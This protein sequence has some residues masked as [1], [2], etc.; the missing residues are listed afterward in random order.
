M[1]PAQFVRLRIPGITIACAAFVGWLAYLVAAWVDSRDSFYFRLMLSDWD[2]IAAFAELF[3]NLGPLSML[4][5][6]AGLGLYAAVWLWSRP[7]TPLRRTLTGLCLLIVFAVGGIIWLASDYKPDEGTWVEPDKEEPEGSL[8]KTFQSQSIA[9][10][11]SYLIY[12]PEGYDRL[13]LKR[14][15]V[16]YHL[17]GSGGRQGQVRFF[18]AR[19]RRPLQAALTE[20]MIVIGVNRV[21]D[22]GYQDWPDVRLPIETVIV[23]DLVPHIDQTYRTIPRREARALEGGSMGGM[24]ALHLGLKFP[25]VFG[26]ISSL[27]PPLPGGP[28]SAWSLAAKNSDSIRGKTRI[29]LLR[30][31]EDRP[32]RRSRA[33]SAFLRHLGIAH[34]YQEIQGAGHG[35]HRIYEQLGDGQVIGF[36]DEAFKNLQP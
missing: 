7:R 19:L 21:T 16:V 26:V 17:P 27:C 4:I 1:K 2:S 23:R 8:Y 3:H 20:P 6:G 18:L 36:F 5:A 33:Y 24:G 31:T 32:L 9:G 14:Y 10:P 13:P 25:E 28:E 34:E 15:P 30:G 12:L 22:A 29:R 35:I 11:V